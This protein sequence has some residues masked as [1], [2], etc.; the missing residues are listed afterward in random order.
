MDVREELSAREGHR[1]ILGK[2][3]ITD[4]LYTLAIMV[5]DHPQE[6]INLAKWEQGLQTYWKM[7]GSDKE[8][9]PDL[10]P[11]PWNLALPSD[12]ETK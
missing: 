3:L 8:D 11:N 7:K 6:L 2:R 4:P 12:N 5:E 10:L 9:L 1:K